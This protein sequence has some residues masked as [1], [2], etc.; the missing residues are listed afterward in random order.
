MKIILERGMAS[1][2]Y[3][4]DLWQYRELVYFLAWRDVAVRYKQTAIGIIWAL[5]RPAVTMLVFVGFRRLAHFPTGAVPEPLLVFAAVLPWQFFS[6]ALAEAANSL[7]SNANLL[8]KVYFPRL[9]IPGAAVVTSLVDFGIT[10][11][12]LAV[13]MAWYGV[14]PGWQVFLLPV[15]VAISFGLSLGLGL[16]LAALNVEYRDFRYVVPFIVQF[17]MFVSPVA[18]STTDVP[19]QWRTLYSLN[20]L[21]GIIDGFRWSL[22]G[23]EGALPE[24]VWISAIMSLLML[25]F[26]IWYFRRVEHSLADVI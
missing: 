1:R 16:F 19:A 18:F 26:G 7:I 23:G 15:V 5:L 21:V 14:M 3:W 24:T 12:L 4:R 8:T 20:P 10:L 2:S 11:G 6:T 17:G 25:L 22:L 13:L 9:V